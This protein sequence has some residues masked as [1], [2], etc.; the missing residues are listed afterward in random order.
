MI[1]NKTSC[2]KCNKD[3]SNSNFRK[4]LVACQGV[5]LKKVRGIDYDP[6]HGYKTSNRKAWNHDLTKATDDR[7]KF[8]SEKVSNSRL[9]NP[10]ISGWRHSSETKDKLSVLACTRLKKNS[11]YSKN[12]E[13]KPGVILESSYEV[14]VAKILDEICVE[15]IKVRKGFIWND[16]GKIRRYIPDFYLPA[17][18]LYLDPKNDY[19]ILKDKLKIESAMHLNNIQVLVLNNSN[20]NK[21]YLLNMLG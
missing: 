13:Y 14:R 16:N 4:H 9:N 7:V 18:D 1:R 20:I 19:L 3:I 12:V 8:N 5:K 17:Y 15:W 6:N 11:K 10:N 21:E 2:T